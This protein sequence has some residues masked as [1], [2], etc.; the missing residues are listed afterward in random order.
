MLPSSIV[1]AECTVKDNCPRIKGFEDSSLT[2]LVC[3]SKGECDKMSREGKSCLQADGET[4]GTCGFGYCDV[5][6]LAVVAGRTV[7]RAASKS[8]W[9]ASGKVETH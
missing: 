5:S 2:C 8:A 9:L 1:Q 7:N 4:E 3:T 6:D